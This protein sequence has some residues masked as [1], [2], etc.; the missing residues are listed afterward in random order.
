MDAPL[1]LRCEAEMIP[2]F[3]IDF[4]D[5][6]LTRVTRWAPGVP[7]AGWFSEV[8]GTQVKSGIKTITFR[9]PDCGYLES[10]APPPSTP[11]SDSDANQ[12]S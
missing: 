6:N 8:K 10:Y 5:G 11:P 9:C 12:P 3:C 1:C 4:G 2:G 7:A